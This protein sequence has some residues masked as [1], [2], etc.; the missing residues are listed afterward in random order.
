MHCEHAGRVLGCIGVHLDGN[1]IDCDILEWHW[2][3]NWSSLKRH[4]GGIRM[5]CDDT[6]TQW[7]GTKR[8]S[9]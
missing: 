5:H 1:G 3:G 2:N 9:G 7:D 8:C 6:G 4:W